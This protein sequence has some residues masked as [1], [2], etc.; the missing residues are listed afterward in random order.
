MWRRPQLRRARAGAPLG[1]SSPRPARAPTRTRSHLR[2]RLQSRRLL[3]PLPRPPPRPHLRRAVTLPGRSQAVSSLLRTFEAAAA[4]LITTRIACGRTPSLSTLLAGICVYGSPQHSGGFA[5]MPAPHA[6]S[7]PAKTPAHDAAQAL[8]EH[9]PQQQEAAQ[10]G[11]VAKAAAVAPAYPP[12]APANNDDE[13]L[14]ISD[15]E[16]GLAADGDGSE[17][18]EDW[19]GDWE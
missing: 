3:Q 1:R 19:G 18:D 10:P 4:S 13:D 6:M 2:P 15:E 11:P 7:S 9:V 8:K 16:E 12:A 5:G 14:E 17:V